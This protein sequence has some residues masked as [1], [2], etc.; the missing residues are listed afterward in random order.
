M[1]SVARKKRTLNHCKSDFKF[2]NLIDSSIV[3]SVTA[4]LLAL[5]LMMTKLIFNCVA[6]SSIG[7]SLGRKFFAETYSH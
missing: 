5:S 1:D 3:A 6:D 4:R 2:A 7:W